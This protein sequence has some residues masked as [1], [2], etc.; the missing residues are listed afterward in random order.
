MINKIK[1]KEKL[2]GPDIK[3]NY[4]SN[5]KTKIIPNQIFGKTTREDDDENKQFYKK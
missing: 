2:S 4:S 3:I 5:I 1:E